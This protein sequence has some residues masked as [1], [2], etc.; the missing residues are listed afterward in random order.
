VLK[1]SAQGSATRERILDAAFETL[2]RE[3]FAQ[4]SARA[5]ARRGGFNQA[6]IFYHFGTLLD[7][8]LAA[9]D[10]V[11]AERMERYREVLGEVKDP[12]E[13]ARRT[14]RLYVED[15]DSGLSTVVAELFAASSGQP[16]LRR[17]ML[18]RMRPWV[19]FTEELIDRFLEGTPFT[20]LVDP[21]AAAGA[22]MAMYLG[23]DLLIHLDGDRT[24]ADELFN[25]GDRLAATVAPLFGGDSR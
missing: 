4:S 10:R 21:H 13:F 11:G 3:G 22:A 15:V 14:R 24:R 20:G 12:V 25:S 6:L 23:L 9:M 17:R 2:R 16:E 1:A 5:I 18:D 8:L 7:L 19:E